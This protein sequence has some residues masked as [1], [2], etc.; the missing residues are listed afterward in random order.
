[1]LFYRVF[2][3]C[4]G[5]RVNADLVLL[6]LVAD[7]ERVAESTPSRL[8][9]DFLRNDLSR[10]SL[11]GDL[12]RLW[13]RYHGLR[14]IFFASEGQ[15]GASVQNCQRSAS[16]QYPKSNS[17]SFTFHIFLRPILGCP[18]TRQAHRT[19]RERITSTMDLA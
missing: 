10:I 2:Q 7:Y 14:Q 11:Q 18:H 15:G 9:F 4:T 12:S 1:M 5:F 19:M 13:R 16:Y 3:E 8:L 6:F 17:G